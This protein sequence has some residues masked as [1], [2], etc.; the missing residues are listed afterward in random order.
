MDKLLYT[1]KKLLQGCI[2]VFK[3]S[4]TEM[5]SDL[6]N[7][8]VENIIQNLRIE[9]HLRSHLF[10]PLLNIVMCHLRTEIYSEKWVLRQF[11]PCE[12][13]ECTYTTLNGIIYY[14]LRLHGIAYCSVGEGK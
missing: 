4:K 13:I 8:L 6:S 9:T 10:Q 5:I 14:T 7:K 3:N 11:C 2:F 12:S 1:F